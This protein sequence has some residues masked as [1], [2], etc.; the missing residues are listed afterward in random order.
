VR[1][2]SLVLVLALALGLFA[3]AS[4]ARVSSRGA[5]REPLVTV[6]PHAHGRVLL[7]FIDS[8]SRELATNAEKMPVL[9][10]LAQEGAAF[11]VEPCR[12]QLTYLCLRAALTGHDDSSLLAVADNFRPSQE[13]PPETLLSAV[14]KQGQRVSVLGTEDF[15][16]Y[17]RS[18]FIERPLAKH[19]E[20]P[21]RV[22][23]LVRTAAQDDAA[24]TIVSL[25]SGDMTAHAH[26]VHSP[27]YAAA[28][29][30]LDSTVGALVD[31]LDTNTSLVVFGDHGHD[32]LGRHLPGTT[33]RTWALYRGPAFRPGFKAPISITDHR[34]LLGVLLGVPTEPIYRGPALA[35]VFRPD[36]VATALGG[37]LPKLEARQGHTAEM[38]V[39][40][41]LSMLGLAL[42]LV[43]GVWLLTS[44]PRRAPF[45]ALAAAASG[46][47]AVVGLAYDP[48]RSLV[49][50]HG[51][52]PERG[53]SLLVPLALGCV[54][55]MLVRQSRLFEAGARPAW[56]PTAAA[57]ALLVTFLL[58]LPTAYYY[59]A[60]RAVVLAGALAIAAMLVEYWRR[61]VGH[62]RERVAPTLALGLAAAVLVTFY[63]V[64]QLGPETGGAAAWA[65]SAGLYTHSTWLPLL[66]AK[67]ILFGVL[68]WPRASERPLDATGAA[69]LLAICVLVELG[70][71]RLPREAYAILFGALLIGVAF[72]RRL[73]PW[74]L[75]AGSL[76]LLDHLYGADA[77]HLAPLETILA[78]TAA[79]L[80]AW[81]RVGV[82]PF[83]KQLLAGFTVTVGFYLMFWPT[84]GFHLAGIDFAYMF[85]WV[86]EAQYEHFWQVIALGV[87]L[88]LA[89]PLVLVL[90][91]ARAQL[92]E[93]LTL[94]VV[95]A[96]LA[97]K[98][99]LLS[100]MISAY[101]IGHTMASQQA[102][103]MLAE[104]LLLLFGVA[105]C[106]IALPSAEPDA[107]T[108]T[109]QQ[110]AG[111][112]G[113]SA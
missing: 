51:D 104:L 73:V 59:G 67:L 3:V 7:V 54:V 97:A 94:T 52:S 13:G 66:A 45:V 57:C 56:L 38:P 26:G 40:R 107:R 101:A 80:A 29:R 22:L 87:I 99:A 34:A 4:T 69:V 110:E 60:R 27:E 89:L 43:G 105:T 39:L 72:A 42:A 111:K 92:R 109:R 50:D 1:L 11:D 15:H 65:L 5:R 91:V 90:G 18:L 16:P 102:L 113:R 25:G 84:V 47:A 48:I 23:A 46:L 78:A 81:Q 70:G 53:L 24:L 86:P 30:R 32:A 62:W 95:T 2:R 103:A 8:L 55:A 58:L 85:Q 76:L 35:S 49:H 100:V 93:P 74:S 96:M 28:F 88:K 6:E 10:R 64:K 37:R 33:S 21:E 77:A 31:A 98:V 63:Q 41:W 20:T 71:V 108:R 112:T 61:N 82:T 44:A 36:W 75:L 14:A 12:D 19:E 9:G 106:L 79:S 83:G 17:R 68:V